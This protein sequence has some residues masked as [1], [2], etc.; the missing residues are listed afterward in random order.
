M[1]SIGSGRD[2]IGGRIQDSMQNR[3]QDRCKTGTKRTVAPNPEN[4]AP[5][6]RP[7]RLALMA[8]AV[9][10]GALAGL[11]GVYGI[12]GFMRNAGDPDC[13]PALAIAH[14]VGPLA[15][16]EVA[17]AAIRADPLRRPGL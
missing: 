11:A 14:P 2:R 16:G 9:V 5:H 4:A 3:I 13:R 7:R 12:G 8:G 15:P 10:A 1:V 17:A 6:P